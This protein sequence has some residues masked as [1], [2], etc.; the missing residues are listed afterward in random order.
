V[1]VTDHELD[2][3][4]AAGQL[5]QERQPA[6]P[7]LP[8][9]YVEAEDLAVAVGVVGGGDQGVHVDHTAVLAD[10]DRERVDP[11]KRVRAG[12]QRPV[13]ERGDLGVEVRGHL[14]DLRTRQGLDPQLFG[15]PFHPPGGHAEQVGGGHHGDQ[16]L[17]GPAAMGQQPLRKVGAVAQLGHGELDG[18]GAGVPL[19]CASTQGT[20]RGQSSR[21]VDTGR[22]VRLQAQ[23]QPRMEVG[24]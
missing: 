7:V 23:P 21:S 12:V 20:Q 4:Q 1:R 14:T 8:G 6:R 24:G 22:A 10:L 18:P 15:Q 9:S 19:C 5:A 13:A 2:A 11:A 16:G 17:L 3:G